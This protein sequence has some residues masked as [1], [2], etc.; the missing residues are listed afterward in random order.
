MIK[1]RKFKFENTE[2]MKIAHNIRYEVFVIG[3]NCPEDIEWEFEEE[4]THFLVFK[5]KEAVATARHRETKNGYKLE[6]F[7][8]LENKRSNGYGHIVLKAIL[9][10]LSNFNTNIYMHAQLDVMPFYEK[11]GF[12]KEGDLFTEA[13]IMHYKMV[14]KR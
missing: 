12:E 9:E 14:L 5:N 13:N 4:S 8:V 7:A 10:D 11:M 3:Q 2:L 6:R 1:I